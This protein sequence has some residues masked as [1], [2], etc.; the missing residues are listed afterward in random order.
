[1]VP[2]SLTCP[3]CGATL[4]SQARWRTVE[5]LY[6]SAV[7]S[8]RVRTILAADFRAAYERS[9]SDD[10]GGSR[11]VCAGRRY[12]ILDT[13]AASGQVLLAQSIGAGPERVVLKLSQAPDAA[14]TLQHEAAIL[15][16]LQAAAIPG[17]AYFS[18]RLP[19]LVARGAAT[20]NVAYG[21]EALVVRHPVGYWG[22]LA[23][24]QRHYPHGIDPRH[25]V[26]MWRRMLDVLGYVHAAGW[27]HGRLAPEHLLVHPGDHGILIIGWSRAQRIGAAAMATAARDLMQTAWSI[28]SLLHGGSDDG[29]PPVAA[30]VPAPLATLLRRASEDADWC[31][32]QGAAGV[33]QALQAAASAAFGPPRFIHFTPTLR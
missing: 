26:W 29:A 33:D 25:A 22:S 28:R 19:Q 27:T 21:T 30:S 1:M 20:G 16:Q 2:V 18:Q 7:V 31:A 12:R 4:P 17:A 14:R 32:R 8:P 3:Q 13:L 15:R 5:C 23:D 9:L 10:D 11:I 6:C 24:V